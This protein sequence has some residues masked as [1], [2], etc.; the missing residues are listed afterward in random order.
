V[1]KKPDSVKLLPAYP[2]AA[3]ARFVG[4]KP[5][6]L[7]A[8]FRGRDYMVGD[9]K[10]RSKPI[11][12]TKSV[13][14]E[15]L[16]FIDLVEAHVFL[17]IRKSYRIPRRN[18][19]TAR[20][21]LEKLKGGLMCLAH[22]DFYL[23]NRQLYVQLDGQL[24][25][26][27]ERGQVVD[28]EIIAKGLSQLNYGSDGYA[29]EFFPS[30]GGVEQRNFVISPSRNFGRLSIA[31]LGVSADIIAARFVRGEKI[32]DIAE[33]YAASLDEIEEAIRWR[34]RLSPCDDRSA[35]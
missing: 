23:D 19:L 25:S 9:Q 18:I 22:K 30:I 16:S 17:L 15:P 13:S 10:R 8:W 12:P 7:R 26:L 4:S 21:H 2:L 6:T 31:R 28:K 34:E 35:A 11:L 29:S 27:S 32:S 1:I 3:V 5:S 20:E 24:I 33:D 14:G